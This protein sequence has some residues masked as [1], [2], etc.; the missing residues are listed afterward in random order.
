[1][2]EEKAIKIPLQRY[3]ELI[4]LEARVDSAV[5][6]IR[7]DEFVNMETILRIIGTGT[8]IDLAEEL[9]RKDEER[10]EKNL[11]RYENAQM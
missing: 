3:E 9:H 5:G 4:Q 1:M 8:A 10:Q 11:E 6:M 2:V 7:S